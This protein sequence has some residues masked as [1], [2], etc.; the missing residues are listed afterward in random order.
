MTTP[1]LEQRDMLEAARILIKHA[2]RD[3]D[4]VLRDAI[5]LALSSA[6]AAGR[7]EAIELCAKIADQAA[8]DT[9]LGGELY[10]ARKIALTIRAIASPPSPGPEPVEGRKGDE[11]QE[12]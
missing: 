3:P 9:A 12:K 10:I 8:D 1:D 5:A 4:N 6:R 11:P 2:V 7:E